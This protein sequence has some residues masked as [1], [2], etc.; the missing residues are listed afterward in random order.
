MP[1]LAKEIN[2]DSELQTSEVGLTSEPYILRLQL[3][4]Y[5]YV[6]GH[7]CLAHSN[8]PR[9][10]MEC[11]GA[12]LRMSEQRFLF[13]ERHS[14]GEFVLGASVFE[15]VRHAFSTEIYDKIRGSNGTRYAKH[16]EPHIITIGQFCHSIKN[17]RSLSNPNPLLS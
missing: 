7:T 2:Y 15:A 6:E 12:V 3:F 9:A 4:Y 17:H 14:F 16:T 8:D 13:F 10:L 1:I 11:T 5:C